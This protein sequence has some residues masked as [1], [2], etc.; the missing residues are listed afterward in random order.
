[1]QLK[2]PS[3]EENYEAE[4]RAYNRFMQ[5]EKRNYMNELL[6]DTEKDHT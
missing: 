1:M 3:S 5:R 2:T 6:R 4:R